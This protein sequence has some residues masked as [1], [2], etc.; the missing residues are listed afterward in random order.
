MLVY[1]GPDPAGKMEIPAQIVSRLLMCTFLLLSF[2]GIGSAQTAAVN[3]NARDT[4]DLLDPT[5]DIN[6]KPLLLLYGNRERI[7]EGTSL[8]IGA[9]LTAIANAR[10]AT[11]L[12]SLVI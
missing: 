5:R 10:K 2:P 4:Y 1:K 6:R 3:L 11:L 9:T 12:E 7:N 8:T